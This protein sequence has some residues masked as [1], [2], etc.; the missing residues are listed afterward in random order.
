MVEDRSYGLTG[1]ASHAGRLPAI[2]PVALWH[3]GIYPGSESPSTTPGSEA[4]TEAS[5][6]AAYHAQPSTGQRSQ[7]IRD[8]TPTQPGIIVRR[9][10]LRFI[11]TGFIA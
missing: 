7:T 10:A 3:G 2:S 11:T 9:C 6:E 8:E 5:T 1:K 4:S